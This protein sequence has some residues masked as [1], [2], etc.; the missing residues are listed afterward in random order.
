MVWLCAGA[1][2]LDLAGQ[3][4]CLLLAIYRVAELRWSEPDA[5]VLVYTG[6]LFNKAWGL[7]ELH[8]LDLLTSSSLAGHGG[9]GRG[10]WVCGL[11]V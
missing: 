10:R 4:P 3:I 9:E 7:G 8:P 6:D 1:L 11:G 2:G 5:V